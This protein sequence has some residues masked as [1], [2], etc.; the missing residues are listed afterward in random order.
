MGAIGGSALPPADRSAQLGERRAQ[1]RVRNHREPL[2]ERLRLA[3]RQ[4]RDHRPPGPRRE[5]QWPLHERQAG[6]DGTAEEQVDSFDDQR[7]AVLKLKRRAGC[8][9]QL[10]DTVAPERARPTHLG[11]IRADDC[12]PL[13]LET[14]DDAPAAARDNRY[15]QFR[16]GHADRAKA[17]L[18]APAVLALACRPSYLC[19]A[20]PWNGLTHAAFPIR[21]LFVIGHPRSR[22]ASPL[23]RPPPPRAAVARPR[24]RPTRP[25]PRVAQRNHAA[26]DD[27]TDCGAIFRPIRGTL[28][29]C[30]GARRGIAR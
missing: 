1:T 6:D 9:A 23:V 16:D 10:Q 13:R 2:I 24:R 11:P 18:L 22:S 5:R 26:A 28:A 15:G 12:G 4:W 3:L 19:R 29:R 30:V 21:N 25:L 27:G 8:D 14:D 7:R 20:A 17:P